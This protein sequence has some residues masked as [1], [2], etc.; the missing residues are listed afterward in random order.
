VRVETLGEGIPRIAIIGGVHGDEP[1]GAD[2]VSRLIEDDPPV[3]KPVK[4]IIANEEALS[5]NVRFIDTDLNRAFGESP[6]ES[7]HEYE[8]AQQLAREI[9]GCLTL[10]LHSTLSHEEPF[11]IVNELSDELQRVCPYL[12]IVAL[13]LVDGKDGR[14]FAS[15]SSLI[16]VE[17]GFQG[18]AIARENA[19]RIA[20]EFLTATQ[21][22][23]GQTIGQELPIFRMGDRLPKPPADKYE[24][25]ASNFEEVPAG[26]VYAS[27]DGEE[28][29]ADEAFSPILLSANGYQHQFG[30]KGKRVGILKPPADSTTQVYDHDNP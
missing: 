25:Y 21:V 19:Y 28:F 9:K 12:S 4:L 20:R 17:A 7:A 8:L 22:L 6:D 1:S 13:V 10:S 15:N 23:P 11:G 29:V 18:S 24:V 30:Y 16:E 14:L 26:T 2:A 5:Q 27:A 3:K